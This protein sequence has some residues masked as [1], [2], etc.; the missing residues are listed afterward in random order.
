[1]ADNPFFNP[2]LMALGGQM[3][4]AWQRTLDLW[5]QELLGDR[6]RLQMLAAKLSEVSAA[7]AAHPED[8]SKLV[9]ALE[10]FESRQRSLEEQ[11]RSLTENLNAVVSFLE[12]AHSGTEKDEE[13]GGKSG[14]TP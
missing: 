9:E 14:D 6:E 3:A 7:R 13:S 5:W 11:V 12:K 4:Q 8:F 10:L 2:N 1:M